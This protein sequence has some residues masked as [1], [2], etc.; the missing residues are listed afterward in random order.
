MNHVGYP[1]N[2]EGIL[3]FYKNYVDSRYGFCSD[4][5]DVP[6]SGKIPSDFITSDPKMLDVMREKIMQHLSAGGD[7]YFVV[8]TSGSK[9][10]DIFSVSEDNILEATEFPQ[11]LSA[12]LAT[13]GGCSSGATRVGFKIKLSPVDSNIPDK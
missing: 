3:D 13:Y 7:E 9:T 10:A 11:I 5:G 2:F 8:Y 12:K 1:H 4:R 6:K